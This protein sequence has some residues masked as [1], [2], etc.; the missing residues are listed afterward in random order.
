MHVSANANRARP[1]PLLSTLS[2]HQGIDY[3]APVGTVVK[4]AGDGRIKFAGVDGEY[5]NTVIIAHGGTI[6]TLYAHLSKFASGLQPGKR[7]KQGETVGYVGS[8]GAA[9]APHLHYEYRVNGAYAD[10]HTVEQ[11]AGEPIPS[12]Y[13]ADFQSK[14]AALLADLEQPGDAVV[15][16]ALEE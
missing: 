1:R 8:S 10:P 2:D 9:T 4:A 3:P 5:G 6:S 14:A 11:P 7:V 13:L 15:T 12:E 16:A